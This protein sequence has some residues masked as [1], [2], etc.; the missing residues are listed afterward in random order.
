MRI[1]KK[2]LGKGLLAS[3]MIMLLTCTAFVSCK[4]DDDGGGGALIQLP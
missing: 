4:N 3:L 1:F 2:N